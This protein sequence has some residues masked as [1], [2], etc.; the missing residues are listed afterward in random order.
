MKN[1]S[2][3]RL[4]PFLFLQSGEGGFIVNNNRFTMENNA[5]IIFF[6]IFAAYF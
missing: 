4:F 1:G 6:R 2:R 5:D 3:M